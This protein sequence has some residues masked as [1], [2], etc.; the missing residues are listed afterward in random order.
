MDETRSGPA[1]VP[2][3]PTQWCADV[4]GKDGKSR[5][6]R[7]GGMFDLGV[8]LRARYSGTSVPFNRTVVN[9]FRLVRVPAG[10]K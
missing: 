10:G 8:Q 6:L 2:V 5:V 3:P 1:E 7:G 4:V 9:G